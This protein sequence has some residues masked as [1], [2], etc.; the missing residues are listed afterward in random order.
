[1]KMRLLFLALFLVGS[2][3]EE[4]QEDRCRDVTCDQPP[5]D[6][7]KD[8]ATLLEY[9]ATGTCN[10]ATGLCDYPATETSCNK[11]CSNGVCDEDLGSDFALLA[12]P[13]TRLCTVAGGPDLFYNYNSQGIVYFKDGLWRLPR[14]Q[15]SF[16][17]DLIDRVEL[18]PGVDLQP[19]GPG[20]FT[21]TI[22]GTPDDGSYVYEY[23]RPYDNNGDAFELVLRAIFRVQAGQA[24]TP[25]LL[26][27]DADYIFQFCNTTISAW[28]TSLNWNNAFITCQFDVRG[29]F[30]PWRVEVTVA[31][32]DRL[33]FHL[34]L[35]YKCC[36]FIGRDWALL[37]E[38]RMVCGPEE[39]VVTDFYSQAFSAQH[40]IFMQDLLAMFE[41]PLGT[42]HG[43]L[44]HD[45]D[46]ADPVLEYL[47]ADFNVIETP[48][49]TN[50]E[51]VQE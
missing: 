33:T 25:V 44:L 42:V 9:P 4:Q 7:C 40:H 36:C 19:T 8:A 12:P 17:S 35:G 21:R 24:E 34:R 45:A 29:I 2:C 38:T 14:D 1:M 26:V 23:R 15:A 51:Y 11:Y 20:V 50:L 31:N 13:G 16:E 41:T 3:G 28:G 30:E 39:R 5:P 27:D 32:G 37:A 6:E 22:Q 10:P 43:V 47:D 18:T 46:G 49:I 48:A